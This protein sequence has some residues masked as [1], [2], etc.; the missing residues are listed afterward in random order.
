MLR[1]FDENFPDLPADELIYHGIV[2]LQEDLI[3]RFSCD[4]LLRLTYA[5]PA[6]IQYFQ[7]SPHAISVQSFPDV[8]PED[9]RSFVW[10]S[11][12]SVTSARPGFD[13]E[14]S[15]EV[16]SGP[17]VL[18][19][20]NIRGVFDGESLSGFQAIGH[21]V[22]GNTLANISSLQYTRQINAIY[23]A[24][25]ALLTNL[26]LESLI[27]QI[28]D[29]AFDAIPGG[30]K[31]ALHLLAR[32]TGELEMRAALGY[33]DNDP[34][35]KKLNL[36]DGVSYI[37]RCVR[38][39]RPLLLKDM[40]PENGTSHEDN[41]QN[42]EIIHSA[43]VAPL[44]LGDE[45]LGAL[46]LESPEDNA[47]NQADLDLISSFAA[48]VTAAIRNAQ[49][50]S[51]VQRQAITDP[52]TELY[53]RRGFFE[54]GEHEIE[55]SH[56]FSRPLIAMMVDID[57]FKVINDKFGHAVGDQVLQQISTRIRNNVRKVDI[58]GRYGGDEF[59]IL[60]PEL[61]IFSAVNVAERLRKKVEEVPFQ[62]G[63]QSIPATISVGVAKIVANMPNLDSLLVRADHALY[64]A[65]NGGRNRVDI[66]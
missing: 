39:R 15:A 19:W 56:R 34:R 43:L 23:T 24:T 42:T 25:M 52:L 64:L 33:Q 46:S 40:A 29:A 53:N 50:H 55:R 45:V 11:L 28:L 65:K 66:G 31:G 9:K 41:D 54:I 58:V 51:E 35:I 57:Q 1:S 3:C 2:D 27:G 7:L 17:Q 30:Q 38:E 13:V 44:I 61:D 18:L 26:D 5:N 14:Y 47:F 21:V 20:W 6:F 22:P 36:K 12:K 63:N 49:L 10:N 37:A 48:T 59:A 60:L 62:A 32:E 8:F 16:A 4:G